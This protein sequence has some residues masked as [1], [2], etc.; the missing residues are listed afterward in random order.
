[1]A[2]GAYQ[3]RA[4]VGHSAIMPAPVTRAMTTDPPK[5]SRRITGSTGSLTGC[6]P[7]KIVWLLGKSGRCARFRAANDPYR[8]KKVAGK[9]REDAPLKNQRFGEHAPVTERPEPQQVDEIRHRGA[10]A[11]DDNGKDR[12]QDKEAA[13][14]PPRVLQRPVNRCGHC[15]THSTGIPLVAFPI[16]TASCVSVQV[17]C[18]AA[19]NYGDSTRNFLGNVYRHMGGQKMGAHFGELPMAA[20]NPPPASLPSNASFCRE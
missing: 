8:M 7:K 20:K 4:S 15:S 6:P 9:K 1:M 13:A 3:K 10:A 18:I 12:E 19:H 5:A 11:E 2:R 16:C 17:T 14:A